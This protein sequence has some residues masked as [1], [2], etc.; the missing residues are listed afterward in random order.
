MF[1]YPLLEV[2][3]AVEREGNFERAAQTQGVTKSAISQRL[4]LLE[5][6]IGAVTVDRNTTTT[7]HFGAMLCRHI[8]NIRLLEN[9][10]LLDNAHLFDMEMEAPVTVKVAVSDDSLSSW[11]M[12]CVANIHSLQNRYFLDVV[13]MD[14]QTTKKDMKNGNT[15]AALSTSSEALPG[16]KNYKLGQHFYRAVASPEYLQRYFNYGVT[17]EALEKAPALRYSELNDQR[18]D[19]LEQHLGVK[20]KTPTYTLPS[21]N[22]IVNACLNGTAWGMS[23][24]LMVDEHIASGKLVELVPN[25]TLNEELFWHVSQFVMYTLS[26]MTNAVLSSTHDKLKQPSNKNIEVSKS[27]LIAL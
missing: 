4:R 8:E 26:I 10:F 7:T 21:S 1:D 25:L 12:D 16:F 20:I 19:W 22:G 14:T 27:G 15:L 5:E 6:R 24:A 17:K 23:S 18:V 2:L 9:N 13:I 11:F 3:H